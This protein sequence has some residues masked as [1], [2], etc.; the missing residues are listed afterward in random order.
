MTTLTNL[1]AATAVDNSD[2][3]YGLQGANS[4]K[5][6][7][8][9]LI[10]S[11]YWCGD[12]TGQS[13]DALQVTTD[14]LAP[15]TT[16][17]GQ[18]FLLRRNAS[19]NANA[20]TTPT[21]DINGR[22]DETLVRP[23]GG[24]LYAGYIQPGQFYEVVID[25]TD[26]TIAHAAS[27]PVS[28]SFT[29]TCNFETNGDFSPTYTTQNGRWMLSGGLFNFVLQ[30]AFTSNAYTTPAGA[31]QIMGLPLGPR[32]L[33]T[34]ANIARFDNYDY[35]VGDNEVGAYVTTSGD[36]QFWSINDAVSGGVISTSRVPASTSFTIWLS[37]TFQ[38][39]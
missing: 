16:V 21:I 36:V 6:T 1:T 5:L 38:V 8:D 24:A 20:T 28:S 34:A 35:Q 37:G 23:D 30:L 13:D 27:R 33:Q 10:P 3:F 9:Q 31:F 11:V 15:T 32:G 2:L 29:P 39:L 4:R 7:H 26:H 25:G 19:A 18:R 14:K 17:D 12:D 22:G